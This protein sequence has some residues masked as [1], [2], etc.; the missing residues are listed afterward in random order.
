MYVL[1]Y[2]R[3]LLHKIIQMTGNAA[4]DTLKGSVLSNIII[5][6]D[7]FELYLEYVVV[8]NCSHKYEPLVVTTKV[9]ES[10]YH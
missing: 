9:L 7:S 5:L 1:L 4:T 6:D 2:W 3:D 8:S 10:N